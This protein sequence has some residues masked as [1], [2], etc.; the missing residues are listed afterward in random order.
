[1]SKPIEDADLRG[2]T[3][4]QHLHWLAGGRID[5]VRLT[6]AC[7][8]AIER[9]AARL[10]AWIAL[11]PTALQQAAASDERRRNGQAIGRL[12]GLTVAIKDNL[13]VAGLV[14]SAGLPGRAG[15]VADSDAGVVARL[16]AAGAVILGKTNL[17]EGSLGT[18]GA[19]PHFGPV[20]NPL[21]HGYTAGGS[22]AGSA[23]AV[24]AGHCSFAIGSDTLGSVRI[25]ASHCGVYG[26]RPTHGEIS[27]RGMLGAA[28]RL[29]CVG[30]LGRAAEDLAIVINVLG[31]HDPADPRSRRRRVPLAPPDWEPGRL[32]SGLLADLAAFGVDAQIQALFERAVERLGNHLG[33]RRTVDFQARD[34]GRTRRAALLLMEAELAVELAHD[35]D[36]TRHPVSP[37]LRAMLDYARGKSAPDYVRAD[38]TLDAAILEARDLF[39]GVDVLVLPSVPHAA[40]PLAEGER[41]ND[42]DLSGFA[43][44]GGCPAISVPMGTL[45][46]GLPV[47]LQLV[48]RPGSDLRLLELAAIC[49]TTLDAAPAFPVAA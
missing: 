47:G 44:L 36:D 8:A 20:H 23:V 10:N 33:Q 14:T 42:A 35:L 46:N 19:N 4:F 9:D 16:R 21:R 30:I 13:D 34:L 45:A 11:D 37:R 41:A 6:S 27:T 31:A 43:S 3:A 29:D 25:P 49:A 7:L 26:L 40:Y 39:V 48:G 18:F 32:S 2:A 22:S 5:S 28:R 1:M 24:A 12:D 38:R 15:R 17:D